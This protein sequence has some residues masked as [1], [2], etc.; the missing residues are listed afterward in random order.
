MGGWPAFVVSIT[1]I[2]LLTVLIGDVA[3][4]F[5]CTIGL[6]DAVNAITFVAVGTSLP[7]S[8]ENHCL[9]LVL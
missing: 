9:L 4:A 1:F 2:G 3:S 6:K 5:G 8:K 7:G